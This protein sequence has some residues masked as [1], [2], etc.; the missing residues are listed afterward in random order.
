M[1]L[2]PLYLSAKLALISTVVLLIIAAP[3]TCWL[4][5]NPVRGRF[6]IESLIGLPLV[7]PPTVL[8]FFLLIVMGPEGVIGRSWE[9]LTG[10]PLVF[11]FTGIVIA[12]MAHSLPYAFQP[13][14]TAFER[15]DRRLLESAYVLGCSKKGAFFRVVLP[16]TVNGLV[17]AAILA[18]AHTMGEFGVIL[19]VGG[20][21]PGRTRVASIAIYEYV[22]ALRYREAWLLSLALVVISYLVLLAV[23]LLN[24]RGEH[25]A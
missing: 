1:D 21:I 24:R 25:G 10:A 7:L 18:F 12:A 3:L 2:T 15:V 4:V 11:T 17:A 22:E 19:M 6:L 8:G 5:F 9:N 20:S 14:K 13:L 23:N 16:N